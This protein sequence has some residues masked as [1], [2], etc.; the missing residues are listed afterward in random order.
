MLCY[1]LEIIFQVFVKIGILK[2]S[3]SSLYEP[4]TVLDILP[5]G[6]Y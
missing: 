3:E 4:N 6:S 5:T 1:G 2:E